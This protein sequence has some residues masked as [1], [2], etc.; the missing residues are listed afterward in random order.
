VVI[1]L[2]ATKFSPKA[3]GQLGFY[4]TAVNHKYKTDADNP[5]VGLLVCR[6]KDN[7]VAQYALEGSNQPIGISE[8]ELSDLIPDDYKSSLP[9]IE[10]IE[11]EFKNLGILNSHKK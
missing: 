8:Y 7:I 10:E 5:T 3:L 11:E 4:V 1:E 2:K 6:T 9:T